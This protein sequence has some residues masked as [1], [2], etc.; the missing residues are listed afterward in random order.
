MAH[1]HDIQAISFYI[2]IHS[3][4][5]IAFFWNGAPK[6]SLLFGAVIPA[7]YQVRGKL[8]RESSSETLDREMIKMPSITKEGKS[9][10]DSYAKGK[11]K[12]VKN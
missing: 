7:L 2:Q 3:H 4:F 6:A 12:S 11:W 9:L 8:Q 1:N 10:L 5:N